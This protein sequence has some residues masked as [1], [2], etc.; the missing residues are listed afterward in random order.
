ME[1]VWT[2]AGNGM[3]FN[4]LLELFISILST[5]DIVLKYDGYILYGFSGAIGNF[6]A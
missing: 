4:Y 3:D 1:I 2:I 6:I 5:M